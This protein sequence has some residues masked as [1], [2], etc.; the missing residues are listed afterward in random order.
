M[1]SGRVWGSGV[2]VRVLSVW[3]LGPAAISVP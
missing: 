3:G 1:S 2:R